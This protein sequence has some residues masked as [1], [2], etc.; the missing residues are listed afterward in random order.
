MGYQIAIRLHAFGDA[1]TGVDF[2]SAKYFSMVVF[3]VCLVTDVAAIKSKCNA[4]VLS[5]VKVGCLTA[6]CFNRGYF[7]PGCSSDVLRISLASLAVCIYA[8]AE[9]SFG[10][11]GRIPVLKEAFLSYAK[12][13]VI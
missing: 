13:V 4:G 6:I 11:P 7:S 9:L 12:I 8:I 1:V 5:G 2:I 10:L 3:Q